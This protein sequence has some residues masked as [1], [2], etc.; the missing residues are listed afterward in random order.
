[1]AVEIRTFEKN[2]CMVC[3]SEGKLK[4]SNLI[5]RHFGDSQGWSFFECN[6]KKCQLLWLNP[7][8]T[9]EDIGKAYI[10]YYTHSEHKKPLINFDFFEKP[11]QA[12]R[13]GY[14]EKMN[15]LKKSLGYLAFLLPSYRIDFDYNVQYLNVL[16]GGKL[17]DFGCGNGTF[18]LKMKEREWETYGLDFDHKAVEYCVSK[19]INAKMGDLNNNYF[20]NDF[21]DAIVLTHVIEHVHE[22]D[23]LLQQF[24]R[25]LKKGGKLI[26]ATPNAGG[27][28]MNHYKEN[29]YILEP[30]R[31]LHLFNPE[32]LETVVKRNDFSIVKSFSSRRFDD[33]SSIV[34]R[35]ITRKGNF[36]LGKEKK[37]ILDL[38]VGVL[39][40]RLSFLLL[41]FNKRIGSELIM[42]VEKK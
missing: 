41:I 16:K 21:F 1:M 5:D 42:I 12:I 11:Y 7:M 8:P 22:V 14:F 23:E 6:N 10:N 35:A 31:H 19:G 3:N 2:K 15:F 26:I 24:K 25:I 32:N 39:H 37:T 13:Y 20:E 38:L 4:Y 33:W 17:L 9:K 30:P 36:K 34:S 27:W 40:K 29:W 18:L 28:Q